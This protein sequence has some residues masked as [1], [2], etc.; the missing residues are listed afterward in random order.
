MSNAI[1]RAM[2]KRDALLHRQAQLLED[3]ERMEQALVDARRQLDVLHGGI[4][5]LDGLM[6][7]LAEA[8]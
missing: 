7:E 3:Y 6:R 1:E 8:E 5:A 2:A 4:E